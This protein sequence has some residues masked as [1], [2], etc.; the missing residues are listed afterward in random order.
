MCSSHIT[1]LSQAVR[2]HAHRTPRKVALL[3]DAGCVDYSE[4]NTYINRLCNVMLSLGVK[5]GDR[6]VSTLRKGKD[7][8]A[9]FLSANRIGAVFA[10]LN[11]T[12]NSAYAQS[13]F[14]IT[15]PKLIV[16]HVDQ[17]DAVKEFTCSMRIGQCK[18]LVAD[19]T[20]PLPQFTYSLQDAVRSASAIDYESDHN[21]DDV[22]YLN[23]TSGSTGEPKAAMTTHRNLFAYSSAAMAS[24]RLT[25]EDIHY[26][27][28]PSFLHPHEGFTRAIVSGGT[29]VVVDWDMGSLW[30]L[31]AKFKVT[32]FMASPS[33][34]SLLVQQKPQSIQSIKTLRVAECGGGP[35]SRQLAHAFYYASRIEPTPVWGSTETTGIALFY[36][37]PMEAYSDSILG[38]PCS[39]YKVTISSVP[40][41]SDPQRK[42]GELCISCDALVHGYLGSSGNVSPILD[43][44]GYFHTNDFVEE[45]PSHM[46]TFL[47]R[48]DDMIKASGFKVF[49]LEVEAAIK[50]HPDVSD[51]LVFGRN[52]PLR[53]EVICALIVCR[54][55]G[56]QIRDLRETCATKLDMFKLPSDYRIVT[57]IPL[58]DAGKPD[59]RKAAM[60]YV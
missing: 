22:V 28:F 38:V 9:T 34:F 6:L 54:R 18:Y 24:L 10:A 45:N 27:A 53:G 12:G 29:A 30:E 15:S 1:S 14:S 23:F 35:M 52:D 33:I 19:S 8:V 13:F 20:G 37:G 25:G 55:A 26:C 31:F 7:M 41:I 3:T 48:K 5:K 50:S 58:T 43:P 56:L 59:R 2:W 36:P 51:A 17:L 46:L 60:I 32:A 16:C 47:G 40:D 39:G 4:L 49:P 57:S 21:W 44:Q 11:V 42:R